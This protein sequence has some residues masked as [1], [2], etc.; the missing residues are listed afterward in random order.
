MRASPVYICL[1]I[2]GIVAVALLLLL[3][4]RVPRT[5]S[6]HAPEM[7]LGPIRHQNLSDAIIA[8]IRRFEPILAEVYPQTH[9]AWVDGFQ[10]D[11]HPEQEVAIWEALAAAYQGFTE[12]RSLSLDAKKEAFGLLLVRSSRDEQQTLSGETLRH[13]SRADAEELMRLYSAPPQPILYEKR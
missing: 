5:Q 9:E 7:K 12:K 4:S 6:A 11:V 13:L 2:A 3:K 10:R 8:R 1:V